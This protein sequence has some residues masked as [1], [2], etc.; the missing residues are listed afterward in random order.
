[1]AT[2]IGLDDFGRRPAE[3]PLELGMSL[4]AAI[5][6]LRETVSHLT[7]DHDQARVLVEHTLRAAWLDRDALDRETDV[8]VWLVRKLRT[9]VLN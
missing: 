2:G 1:M 8:H 9:Q 3:D 7:P 4:I 6:K 5:P